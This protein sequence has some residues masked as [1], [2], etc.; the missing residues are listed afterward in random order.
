MRARGLAVPERHNS[1][2]AGS[3]PKSVLFAALTQLVAK[4]AAERCAEL[5][6]G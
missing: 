3:P 2:V 1:L 6:E 4:T 5:V